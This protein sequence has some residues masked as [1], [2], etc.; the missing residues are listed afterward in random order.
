MVASQGKS[1]LKRDCRKCI[2]QT[3]TW[4]QSSASASSGKGLK[5]VGLVLLHFLFLQDLRPLS[6]GYFG[7]PT[8]QILFLQIPETEEGSRVSGCRFFSLPLWPVLQICRFPRE[9][10]V[11]YVWINQTPSN[12]SC[13]S[14]SFIPSKFF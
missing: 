13:S 12:P 10:W 7:S 3:E 6:V 2:S 8:L 11:K 9:K 1:D 5:N 14:C 4:T